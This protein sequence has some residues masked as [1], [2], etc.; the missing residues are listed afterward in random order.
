[1]KCKHKTLQLT[2]TTEFLKEQEEK[3][4]C[5]TDNIN[6]W[7]NFVFIAFPYKAY[8]IYF[9]KK[10]HF[11]DTTSRH[12]NSALHHDTEAYC[13]FQVFNILSI[14]YQSFCHKL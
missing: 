12:P 8:K 10:D 4:N 14:L 1:M 6:N 5:S 9:Y 7:D 2:L 11:L 13:Y 3:Q